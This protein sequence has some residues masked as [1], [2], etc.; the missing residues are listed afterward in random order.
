MTKRWVTVALACG[1][2]M[3]CAEVSGDTPTKATETGDAISYEAF[4]AVGDGKADDLPA[5]C[6]AHEY[7]NKHGKRVKSKPDA[8]YH[9]GRRALTVVM[10]TDTDWGTSRFTI[11][12]SQEVEDHRKPLF[13][14][15][16]LLTPVEVKVER[17]ARGQTRL[18]PCPPCDC[19][20]YV[21]NR[22]RKI[23]IRKG[24]NQNDGTPQQEVFV[25]RRD[26]TIEGAITWDYDT[27]TQV[28]ARPI[29]PFRLVVR[30]GVFTHVGNRMRQEKGYN[31]WGR[32]IKI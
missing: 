2:L 15:R 7:A 21:Q 17:L 27:V 18:E 20:V 1:G 16:S 12:D 23:F 28:V 10:A 5:I 25:F 32:N 19:V 14:I 22:N 9:L 29:D 6:A 11:D 24:L 13:E 30:G 3:A 4:G 26:G 8:V 31:Y